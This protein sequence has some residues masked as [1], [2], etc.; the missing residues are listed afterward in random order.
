MTSSASGN[1]SKRE[2]E[3]DAAL[4]LA[5]LS[6]S[7]TSTGAC[8]RDKT[9]SN[10][11]N[12]TVEADEE[13]APGSAHPLT[14][15]SSSSGFRIQQIPFPRAIH[16]PM[17]LANSVD[18]TYT[19]YSVIPDNVLSLLE[20]GSQQYFLGL[21]ADQRRGCEIMKEQLKTIFGKSAPSRKH[22]GGVSKPFPGKVSTEETV[23]TDL[24]I[25][26]LTY[27]ILRHS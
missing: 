18:H 12:Q 5:S 16:Q 10:S 27:L 22:N 11:S 24:S 13:M 15:Y 19:D 7:N 4:A 3:E 21:D 9:S 1:A 17:K 14:R 8:N 26:F 2:E 23:G 25:S 20:E 6:N